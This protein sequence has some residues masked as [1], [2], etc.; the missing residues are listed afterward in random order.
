MDFISPASTI[1]NGYLGMLERIGVEKNIA[2]NEVLFLSRIEIN[3][4]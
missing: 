2:T 3:K 4:T 1:K